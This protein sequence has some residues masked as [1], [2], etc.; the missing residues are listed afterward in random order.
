MVT[1]N[2]QQQE[3]QGELSIRLNGKKDVRILLVGDPG[4]GKT[5]LIFS[6]VSE[7]FAE[8]VPPRAEEITIPADVTPEKVTTQ[9][10]DFSAQE[11]N[12]ENL[13]QEIRK[14][15]VIC[16]V[17]A[18]DD[19]DSIDKISSYWLPL[20]RDQL[21][22]DHNVPVVLVGN[23]VD[24]VEYS[25]LESI[26][27]IMNQFNE[28]ET[29]VECS[30]KTL[31]NISELFF[32]AQKA[33]LHPTLPLYSSYERDLTDKCKKALRRIFRLCDEDND[34][35]LNDDEL[36]KF[37]KRCFNTPLKSQ[38]LEDIK[39]IVKR[40]L[41]DGIFEDSITLSGFLFL[42]CLF[43]QRGRHEA[44]WAVLRKF[45]YNDRVELE[46]E[47]FHNRPFPDNPT[48]HNTELSEHLTVFQNAWSTGTPALVK[49]G[50][51]ISTIAIFSIFL[52]KLIRKLNIQSN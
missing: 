5:S 33:V 37:Q 20:I 44:T 16:I 34:G 15:H 31:K 11:Q 38:A 40:S 49:A 12:D 42:H 35:L 23:K 18:V 25:S 45:G 41:P 6:L 24:L 51:G 2:D 30:A 46:D 1:I 36:N 19:D 39:N 4:V 28:I 22:E 27:P 8:E 17:Y 50:L 14:S 9:I 32:Y 21:G 3:Q 48:K 13:Y 43:I 29:C 7:E 52:Y 26:L 47:S 10:V